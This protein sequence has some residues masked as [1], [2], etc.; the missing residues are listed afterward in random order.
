VRLPKAVSGALRSV[1]AGPAWSGPCPVAESSTGQVVGGAH[2]AI[3]HARTWLDAHPTA[4]DAGYVLPP[5]I[6]RLASDELDS[7]ILQMVD[8]WVELNTADHGIGFIAKHLSRKGAM[9]DTVAAGVVALAKAKPYDDE[10]VWH[11]TP[12]ARRLDNY[13]SLTADVIAALESCLRVL[14]DQETVV[15]FHSQFDGLL[16]YLVRQTG[17]CCGI[18]AARLDDIIDA[19]LDRPESLTHKCSRGSYYTALLARILSLLY[20]GRF[21]SDDQR[22]LLERLRAWVKHW[23]L[24]ARRAKNRGY[25]PYR[26]SRNYRAE[27]E[28]RL[29]R[30]IGA[31][32]RE[33]SH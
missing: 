15:N 24:G 32:N 22:A 25:R 28:A 27:P 5:L 33:C 26:S 11:L 7:E 29:P 13:S 4:T 30:L 18:A 6:A 23:Q 2:T 21:S 31:N 20:A 19:W 10:I 3:T 8:R 12:I 17:C 9:T 1:E 16:E 14:P